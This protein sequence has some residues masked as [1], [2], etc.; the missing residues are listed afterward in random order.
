M[1]TANFGYAWRKDD[2]TLVIG[3]INEMPEPM[4]PAVEM[5]PPPESGVHM[6]VSR[7]GVMA[8]E[9]VQTFQC[10]GSGS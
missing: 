1:R 6:L 3:W 2:G 7:T 5:P 8:W 9:A 10:P 4:P